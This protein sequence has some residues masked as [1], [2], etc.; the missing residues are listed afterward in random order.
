MHVF[1]RDH[2]CYSVVH[3]DMQGAAVYCQSVYVCS[4]GC[5]IDG[6]CTQSMV[7]NC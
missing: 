1:A 7:S 4:G 5:N 3:K 6:L 2:V